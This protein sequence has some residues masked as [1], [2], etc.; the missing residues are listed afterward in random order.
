[1]RTVSSGSVR[2]DIG[3]LLFITHA[4]HIFPW[5]PCMACLPTFIYH[6]NQPNVELR[7]DR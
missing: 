7:H 3:K 2:K 4:L 1:M 5:D 6:K